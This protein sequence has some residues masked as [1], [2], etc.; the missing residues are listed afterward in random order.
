MN[1]LC[2][3]QL[4]HECKP[5][6]VFNQNPENLHDVLFVLLFSF[7]KSQ[8]RVPLI[9][10][11]TELRQTSRCLGADMLMKLLAN[12]CRNKNIKTSITVGV[13][14]NCHVLLSS[15]LVIHPKLGDIIKWSS[16]CLSQPVSFH[17][18]YETAEILFIFN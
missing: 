14:G 11:S 2:R 15:I 12:Y 8:S 5:N 7:V 9:V 18:I 1:L 3:E 10:A 17:W 6:F 16:L 4:V 13:V